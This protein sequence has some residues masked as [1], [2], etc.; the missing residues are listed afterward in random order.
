MKYPKE[1]VFTL[2]AVPYF[3]SCIKAQDKADENGTLLLKHQ[4]SNFNHFP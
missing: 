4:F 3:F 1:V 2:S